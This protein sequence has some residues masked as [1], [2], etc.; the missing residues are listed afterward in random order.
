VIVVDASV[1]ATAL[2]DDGDDGDVARERLLIDSDLH[3][4]HLLDAEVLAALRGQA[5]GGSLDTRRAGQALADLVALPIARY[6]HSPFASRVWQLRESLAVY[7]ALYVALA[8]ALGA[9]LVTGD[10][11]LSRASGVRCDV[12]LLGAA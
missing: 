11:R 5:L 7:D 10:A 9:P 8:E 6:P 2:A 3:A 1:L 12:E 4:P